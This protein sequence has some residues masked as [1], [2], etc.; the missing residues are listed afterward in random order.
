M[1]EDYKVCENPTYG[2]IISMTGALKLCNQDA[3]TSMCMCQTTSNVQSQEAAK[4]SRRFEEQ[5]YGSVLNTNIDENVCENCGGVL[6]ASNTVIDK[7]KDILVANLATSGNYQN[8]SVGKTSVMG[9][10]GKTKAG[11]DFQG[12]NPKNHEQPLYDSVLADSAIPND[13]KQGTSSFQQ[14]LHSEHNT[15]HTAKAEIR[16]TANLNVDKQIDEETIAA[17]D[18]SIKQHSSIDSNENGSL[19]SKSLIRGSGIID[20]DEPVRGSDVDREVPDGDAGI[21]SKKTTGQG[22]N[23]ITEVSG[24]DISNDRHASRQEMSINQIP[25]VSLENEKYTCQNQAE[26][27]NKNFNSERSSGFDL[28]RSGDDMDAHMA[29]KQ[30]YTILDVNSPVHEFK[31]GHIVQIH[32]KESPD[33]YERRKKMSLKGDKSSEEGRELLISPQDLVYKFDSSK[34]DQDEN[35]NDGI[36]NEKQGETKQR[37]DS[38]QMITTSFIE[39]LK[40]EGRRSSQQSNTS[41]RLDVSDINLRL[42]QKSGTRASQDYDIELGRRESDFSER[43]ISQQAVH[44]DKLSQILKDLGNKKGRVQSAVSEKLIRFRNKEDKKS[45]DIELV[46]MQDKKEDKKEETGS[47][48]RRRRSRASIRLRKKSGGGDVESD[49]NKKML[50]ENKTLPGKH[51]KLAVENKDA[52]AQA[53]EVALDNTNIIQGA[54]EGKESMKEERERLRN[55]MIDIK[56]IIRDL[57]NHNNLKSQQKT[58]LVLLL[59]AIEADMPDEFFQR[60]QKSKTFAAI[61]QDSVA[62]KQ[63]IIMYNMYIAGDNTNK[64]TEV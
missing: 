29:R 25:P 37:R 31:V 57:V 54:K 24:G 52:L 8:V 59:W 47:R 55:D 9:S 41:K 17:S 13:P 6:D 32:H 63:D 5:Q 62:I 45:S 48:R 23:V 51:E 22:S 26:I 61:L 35:G 16:K 39:N 50:S 43:P 20:R 42:G 3:G 36:A 10:E 7:S 28:N 1:R 12:G 60:L 30:H 18:T 64:I 11:V 15:L 27:A 46:E 40:D 49:E 33:G 2:N 4:K 56:E 14:D 19:L 44:L 38:S 58:C 53:K 21:N 34:L